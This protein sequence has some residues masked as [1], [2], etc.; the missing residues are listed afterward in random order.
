MEKE[1]DI[2]VN[3]LKL[4]HDLFRH[5]IEFLLTPGVN[6]FPYLRDRLDETSGNEENQF[7]LIDTPCEEDY[8]HVEWDEN[9]DPFIPAIKT[10]L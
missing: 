2:I 9:G 6:K 5:V 10:D 1:F 7:Y 8:M 3:V 4:N